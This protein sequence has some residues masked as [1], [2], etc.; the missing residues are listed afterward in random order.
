M[1]E[2]ERKRG[3]GKKENER[4]MKEGMKEINKYPSTLN[5]ATLPST[6]A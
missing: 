1:K 5:I 4:K 2:E 3:K 6:S